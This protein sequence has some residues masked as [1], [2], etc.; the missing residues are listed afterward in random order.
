MY[1]YKNVYGYKNISN[2]QHFTEILLNK[3]YD[4]SSSFS[5]ICIKEKQI[6]T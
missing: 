2:I 5:K 4:T 6:L 1:D 3:N